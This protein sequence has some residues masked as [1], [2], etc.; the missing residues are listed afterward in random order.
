MCV[1]V[2]HVK[3]RLRVNYIDLTKFF[4]KLKPS[5]RREYALDN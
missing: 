4:H 2:F 1:C 5:Y 3:V